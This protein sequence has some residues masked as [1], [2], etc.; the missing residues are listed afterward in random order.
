MLGGAM[1]HVFTAVGWDILC[2]G[3]GGFGD[4]PDPTHDG[5]IVYANKRMPVIDRAIKAIGGEG[6][7]IRF[8]GDSNQTE[9]G[10]FDA[11]VSIGTID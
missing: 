11:F 2:P 5:V 3:P 1:Q 4:T 6:V 7:D 9:P 8:G 10:G